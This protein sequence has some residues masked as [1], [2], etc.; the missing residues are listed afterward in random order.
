MVR[1][2][3][4]L[5]RAT[6]ELVL[7]ARDLEEIPRYAYDYGN[8]GWEGRLTEVFTRTLGDSLGRE[9]VTTSQQIP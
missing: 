7:E 8:G 5:N 1:L 3:R 4:R 2:Q 9:E 6:G